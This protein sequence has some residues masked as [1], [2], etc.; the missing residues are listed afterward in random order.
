MMV[1]N[2]FPEHWELTHYQHNL[3]SF[4]ILQGLFVIGQG[5]KI[6]KC[7]ISASLM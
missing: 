1:K 7:L 5:K 4:Y 6:D 2:R 3:V